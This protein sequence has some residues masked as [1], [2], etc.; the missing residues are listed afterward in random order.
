MGEALD[1]GYSLF[2]TIRFQ[3]RTPQNTKGHYN[4]IKNSA[5]ALDI[6][7]EKTQS[8]FD[9][10]LNGHIEG[11]GVH[12]GA[13]R[14]QLLKQGT[15]SSVQIQIKSNRYK[16]DMYLSGFKVGLTGLVKHSDSILVRHKTSNYME[17]L[18]AL[19]QMKQDGF[20][21]GLIINEKS[22]LTEGTY[23]NIFLIKEGAVYTPPLEAGLLEGTMRAQVLKWCTEHHI[24]VYL[25]DIAKDTLES[26][27]SGFL[28][29]ALMGIMPIRQIDQAIHFELEHDLILRISEGVMHEWILE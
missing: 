29:N 5:Q 4:R 21:E 25:L 15:S 22:N 20:D 24:R 6:L 9:H 13:L 14:Y 1:Y 8:D 10:E 2:E 12:T 18:L 28:T 17:N 16:K 27:E 26:Y 19:R 3:E 11:A 23:T 7:F